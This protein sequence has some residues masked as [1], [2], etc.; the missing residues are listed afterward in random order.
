LG[1]HEGRGRY[2]WVEG[3]TKERLR[4]GRREDLSVGGV[5]E[6][7]VRGGRSKHFWSGKSGIGRRGGLKSWQDLFVGVRSSV[8]VVRHC[9]VLQSECLGIRWDCKGCH[10]VNCC[11]SWRG[12]TAMRLTAAIPTVIGRHPIRKTLHSVYQWLLQSYLDFE[13]KR[14]LPLSSY[15][16][17]DQAGCQQK[18][19][20]MHCAFG[21]APGNPV[22]LSVSGWWFRDGNEAYCSHCSLFA[23]F[24]IPR[25]CGM[26][27]ERI[28]VRQ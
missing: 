21:S 25:S 5:T 12:G 4:G 17:R 1:L 13:R 10:H 26:D 19:A 8:V 9:F 3:Q 28:S 14:S 11:S 7:R 24:C 27:A 22:R 23:A 15:R 2:S 16:C 6:S 20:L 18:P